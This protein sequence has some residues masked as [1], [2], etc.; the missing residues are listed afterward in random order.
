MKGTLLSDLE[1]KVDWVSTVASSN[2]IVSW[3]PE[4]R[5]LLAVWGEQRF[6]S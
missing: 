3:L 1:A 5:A 4:L 2:N 6:Q